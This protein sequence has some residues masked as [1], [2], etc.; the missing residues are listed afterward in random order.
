[1]AKV[2]V[3]RVGEQIKKELSQILQAELK[4]PRV[5]FITVTGVDVTNDLSQAKVYL[6]V[7]GT[8]QQKEDSLKA[9]E[10]ATGFIRSELGK[11]IRLRI[12]PEL[13]F[14]FDT[15]I[16]YGSRIDALLNQIN[17]GNPDA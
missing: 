17:K 6:S 2:R 1:M 15:S 9:I 8:D 13:L 7:M 12:T 11:R 4:D 5:G 14:Q 16:E 10:K 3:G